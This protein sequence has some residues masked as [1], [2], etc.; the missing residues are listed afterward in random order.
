[1]DALIG[2]TGFV[3]SNLTNKHTFPALFNSTNIEEMRG[4][5]FDSVVC[6]GVQA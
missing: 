5:T 6:A 1:M 2:H 4:G 3:G